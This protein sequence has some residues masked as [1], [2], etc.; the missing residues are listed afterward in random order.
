MVTVYLI[1]FSEKYEHAQH[2]IGSTK[3][4]DQRIAQHC[5]GASNVPLMLAVKDAGISW[6]VVRTWPDVERSFEFQLKKRHKSWQLCPVC[7]PRD[8]RK[9]ANGR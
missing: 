1:H 8:W 4:L 7:N 5:S 2:Y 3:N 6:R 9:Q